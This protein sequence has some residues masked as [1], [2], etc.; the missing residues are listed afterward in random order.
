MIH[1]CSALV[2]AL[3]IFDE[4]AET[5][6]AIKEKATPSNNEMICEEKDTSSDSEIICSVCIK[7][8]CYP[9]IL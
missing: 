6:P 5:S 8:V 4:K 3:Q 7:D 2:V 9:F 1:V